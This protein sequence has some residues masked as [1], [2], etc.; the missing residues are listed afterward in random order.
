[1]VSA[2]QFAFSARKP[3]FSVFWKIPVLVSASYDSRA[4]AL[5]WSFP[6]EQFMVPFPTGWRVKRR[7]SGQQETGSETRLRPVSPPLL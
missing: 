6:S 7:L 5:Y 1:M 4:A 3:A 2:S